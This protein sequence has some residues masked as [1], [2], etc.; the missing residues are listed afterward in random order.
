[1]SV[2]LLLIIAFGG[3]FLTYFL[4]KISHR[5]RDSFAVLISCALV[6]VIAY[7]YGR[8]LERTFYLGFLGLPLLL[9]LNTLSWFFAI[10]IAVVG[11]LSIIFSLSYIKGKERTNFYYLM[12]LLVNSGMLGIVLSGDLVSFYIFWEIMSWSAFLL[13]CY[14]R[15]P[16]LAAGMKYIIMSVVGSVAMLIGIISL[17]ASYGTLSISAIAP[18]IASAS[19]AYVLFVLISFGIG[20]GIKG[21]IVPLHTWLPDA[22]SE[23]PSPFSSVLSGI[24]IGMGIYGVFAVIFAVLGT[25]NIF[26]LLVI[27]GLINL[28]MGE[29]SAFTQNNI[30]RLLAYSTIGQVGL[31]TFAIGIATHGGIMGS[32][33]QIVNH[34]L[35]KSLLFLCVGYM[36]Y[37]AGSVSI[38]SL[39]G[40]GRRMPLTSLAFTIGAFSLVGLPPF[41]GF[42]SKFL[43]L[44]AAL[45]KQEILFTVLAALVLLATIIEGA[46][47][48]RVVQVLYFKGA[49]GHNSTA[50]Q[51]KKEEA[52][53]AALI[54]IFILTILIAI[55]GV[56]PKPV[57]D[58]LS[59]AASD[60]LRSV[61]YGG[62]VLK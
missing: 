34:A 37:R 49:P 62:S 17:Y 5:V 1:M 58:I 57:T 12:M 29:M 8:S 59:S 15:G 6:A 13:I 39:N 33:F 38:S 2:E 41:A 10:T 46:Y 32:L 25:R 3:A 20:F 35:A 45:A 31:I 4:G 16:A 21:A 40:M 55:I 24:M 53:L 23:A 7:L 30:K 11:A 52:P 44:K 22:H 54:A 28:F 50:A 56:Y 42:P 19:S 36:T 61:E 27:L 47:F 48:F 51:V 9:R 43:I 14:N 18:Q 60:L 26:P